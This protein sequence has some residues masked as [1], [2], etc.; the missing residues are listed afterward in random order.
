MKTVDTEG[1]EITARDI[2]TAGR[3][4]L[5]GKMQM[6]GYYQM[7]GGKCTDAGGWLAVYQ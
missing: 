7:P 5:R 2:D 1:N 4:V 6:M 3:M